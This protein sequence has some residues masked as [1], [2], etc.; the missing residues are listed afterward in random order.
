MKL[1]IAKST[2]YPLYGIKD[3]TLGGETLGNIYPVEGKDNRGIWEINNDRVCRRSGLKG[4]SETPDG[5]AVE[6]KDNCPILRAT[7]EHLTGG[8][9]PG[10]NFWSWDRSPIITIFPTLK[11]ARKFARDNF[12]TDYLLRA[13]LVETI[14][15]TMRER[16][17]AY[18]ER[19][20]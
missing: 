13:Y 17:T 3:I 12:S 6:L 20:Q 9:Y 10:F 11:E 14:L 8:G 4:W 7:F 1:S 18:L 5:Y 19:G 2:T 15:T 16:A